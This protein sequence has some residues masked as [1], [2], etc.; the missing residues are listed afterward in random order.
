MPIGTVDHH[1]WVMQIVIYGTLY[2]VRYTAA[3]LHGAVTPG[4]TVAINQLSN[5]I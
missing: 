2:E 4:V 5:R 1:Q 3:G